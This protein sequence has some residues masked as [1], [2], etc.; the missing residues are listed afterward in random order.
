MPLEDRVE[1]NYYC[2]GEWFE[3]YESARAYADTVFLLSRK[4]AVVFTKAEKDSILNAIDHEL[5]CGK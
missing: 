2:N 4:Y 5:E 3:N 1:K